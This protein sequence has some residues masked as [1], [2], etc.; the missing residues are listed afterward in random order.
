MTEKMLDD[1]MALLAKRHNCSFHVEKTN[2]KT[3][4]TFRRGDNVLV[5]FYD[6]NT[7]EAYRYD[8][9]TLMPPEPA[10]PTWKKVTALDVYRLILG[11]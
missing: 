9:K 4:Y 8:A 7:F 1:I 6:G 10:L 3:I 11:L 2:K 5:V